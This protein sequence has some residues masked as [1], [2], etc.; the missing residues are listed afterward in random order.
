MTNVKFNN[1]LK[2]QL[3]D[4]TFKAEFDAENDCLASALVVFKARTPAGITQTELAKKSAVPESTIARIE[5]GE[6]TSV[7]TLSKL[8]AALN[9]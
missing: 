9:L 6:N 1:Y 2:R 3:Q 8:A 5:D 7:D 4:P